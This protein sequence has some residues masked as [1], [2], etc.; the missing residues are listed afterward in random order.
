MP[1]DGVLQVSLN[2]PSRLNAMTADL[3]QGLHAVFDDV[4]LRRDVRVVI[5]TGAGR[6]FCAG[7]DLSGY[8][9]APGTANAGQMERSFVRV[10][11]DHASTFTVPITT[12]PILVR[13]LRKMSLA[14]DLFAAVVVQ[15]HGG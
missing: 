1:R 8:G 13:L 2:R 12:T 5:L 4:A 14:S 10:Q 7:L 15:R 6:G 11:S 9:D 3:V